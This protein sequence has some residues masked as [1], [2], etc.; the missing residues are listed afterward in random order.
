[1]FIAA[2][3]I[4]QYREG[5]QLIDI[6]LRQPPDER[7]AITDIAN[8]YL[9]TASRQVDAADADRQAGRSPGSRA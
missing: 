5:D 6:V 8:A 3:T 9:P 2:R 4:G 1:M 7:D